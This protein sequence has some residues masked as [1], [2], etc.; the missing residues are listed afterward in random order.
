MNNF[1]FFFDMCGNSRH[2]QLRNRS[3]HQLNQLRKMVMHSSSL[4]FS[5]NSIRNLS[6]FTDCCGFF[7]GKTINNNTTTTG[8][9]NGII[10]KNPLPPISIPK[11]ER[12]RTVSFRKGMDPREEL[13]RRSTTPDVKDVSFYSILLCV[14]QI[15]ICKR[16][17]FELD[18]L[19]I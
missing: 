17:D 14:N 12:R 10:Q 4:S 6:Y 19:S 8:N 9:G 5:T 3:M 1:L 7:A 2:H 13:L 16:I 18:F 11:L 15:I